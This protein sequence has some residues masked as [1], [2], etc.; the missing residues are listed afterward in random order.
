[1]IITDLAVI[2]V[3]ALRTETLV[4]WHQASAEAVITT[5][6]AITRIICAGKKLD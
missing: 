1:M 2:A 4:A 3:P 6:I 5:R